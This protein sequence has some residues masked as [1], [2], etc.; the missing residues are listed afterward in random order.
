MSQ[1]TGMGTLL[2]FMLRRDR[3]RL[4]LWVGGLTLLAT[5]F[6]VALSVVLDEESLTGM[7][8]L[9][10]S[11]VTALVGGPGYGFD[12]ITV[13]RFL[14]GL[15]GTYLML[16]AAFMS[17]TTITRHTRAEEQH[18]RAELVLAD[19]VGRHA[20]LTAALLLTV[21]MN[22]LTAALMTGVVLAAPLDDPPAPGSTVLFTASI[23][24]VG[25]A[26]AGVAAATAQLSPYARTCTSL[27]GIV[28]AVSFVV[29]GLGDMSRVQ[30]G[31]L[32]W[33]SWLSPLGWAQQT[34]PYTLD[35]WWP[36]L[37]P[38]LLAVA[39]TLAAFALR[40]RRDLGSGALTD[41]PGPA[42]AAGWLASP[43]ALAMRLQ[44]GSIVGWSV[45]VAITGLVLGAF[46]RA[47]DESAD[48]LPAEI[49][50]VIG[51]T[52]ALTEG[53][54]GFMS[55]YFG[56]FISAFAILAVQTLAAQEP[57]GH[58]EPVL[59]TAVGRPHW[60]L[61]W[62]GVTA[63]GVLWLSVLAGAAEGLGAALV[64][65][66]RSLF[67]PTLLGHAV[68]FA[69]AFLLLGAALVLYGVAPR[70]VGLV[71]LILIIGSVLA[72]FGPMLGLSQTWLNLSPFQH[73]GQHPATAVAWTAVTVL[74][75]AG[76][77]LALLGA[78]AF[79]RRDLRA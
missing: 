51:G 10:S 11:P 44:R 39:A 79:R 12:Q 55:V 58:T 53:F 23:G 74:A 78:L 16:G 69:P 20:P 28:L 76:I 59:A 70:L 50:A 42:E 27:A 47:I 66:D 52:D 57:G 4:P 62:A 77:A 54:L 45:G 46:T 35:R 64:T 6:T 75:A 37:F 2:G 24:A 40:S 56:V 65:H 15:Y 61:S 29:R 73:V 14:A 3:L 48:R 30:G 38:L 19:I 33:L 13:P 71:W 31:S 26:F 36:L 18:G 63:G 21:A 25:L 43:T 49:L 22:V 34:A 67:G 8:Q 72:F 17:M 60:V 7:A 5:Y 32:A 41:R 1:F 68:Q 9:A